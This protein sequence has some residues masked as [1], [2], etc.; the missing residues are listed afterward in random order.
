MRVPS[1]AHVPDNAGAGT[2][3]CCVGAPNPDNEADTGARLCYLTLEHLRLEHRA[4]RGGGAGRVASR[5]AA[6]PEPVAGQRHRRQNAAAASAPVAVCAG[7][8]RV[9]A[10]SERR[11]RSDDE[12]SAGRRCIRHLDEAADT[13]LIQLQVLGREAVLFLGHPMELLRD[14]ALVDYASRRGTP[15]AFEDDDDS[16][17][18]GGGVARGGG[19]AAGG[20]VA[21]Q[22]GGDPE[23]GPHRQRRQSHRQRRAEPDETF[24]PVRCTLM[25]SYFVSVSAALGVLNMVPAWRLDGE[26]AVVAVLEAIDLPQPI[27][28]R[29]T[30]V[31]CTVCTVLLAANI[32]V[33]FWQ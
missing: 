9:F 8:R 32:A 3:D 13:R 27:I 7:A 1:S 17:G 14:V 5:S 19:G 11:C 10:G 31:I 15:P 18:G 25:L 21:G 12:C 24:W 29:L 26:F 30:A 23:H 22:Q 6:E 4:A 20:D 2:P 28:K 16:V 33:S